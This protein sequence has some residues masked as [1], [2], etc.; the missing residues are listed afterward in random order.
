MREA[1]ISR[2]TKETSVRC[3][4]NLDG[5][6]EGSSDTGIGF[7]DHM[8]ELLALHSK[9]DLYLKA[10]GDLD[11]DDH[12][13]IED[14]GIAMGKAFRE[15][16]GDRRGIARYGTFTLPMD[17]SLAMVSLDISGRPYLVFDCPF[18]RDSIGMMASEMVEEFMRAFA[19][20]AGIT[21]HVKLL[22][23]NNDHHKAEAV[24]KALGHALET[25][26]EI[27]GEDMP[28]TKGMLE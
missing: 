20:N 12:H 16:V 2:E 28:C 21:L 11:V 1:E 26:L 13:T 15:A 17:E 7:F 8:I 25:A 19:F 6:G 5:T 27:K 3:V 24:F 14:C 18:T 22:Y 23:G 9:T 4:W 10:S